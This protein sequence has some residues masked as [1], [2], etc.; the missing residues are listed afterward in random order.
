MGMGKIEEVAKE[1]CDVLG[2][3]HARKLDIHFEAGKIATVEA[4]FYPV[5]DNIKQF[6]VIIKKYKLVVDEE[7]KKEV[8]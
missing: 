8:L 7:S 4:E 2:I 6:P 5:I 3:E 1:I